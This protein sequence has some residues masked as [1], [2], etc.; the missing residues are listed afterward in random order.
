MADVRQAQVMEDMEENDVKATIFFIC[1]NRMMKTTQP[2]YWEEA[3][4]R[5]L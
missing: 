2:P 5:L 1:L 3:E 4:V